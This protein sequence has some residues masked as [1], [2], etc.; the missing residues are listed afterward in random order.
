MVSSRRQLQSIFHL[1]DPDSRLFAFDRSLM[2]L[3]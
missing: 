1:A 3:Q 2:L